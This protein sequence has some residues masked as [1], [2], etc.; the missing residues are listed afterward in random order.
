MFI[1]FFIFLNY[2][3]SFHVIMIYLFKDRKGLNFSG[4]RRLLEYFL[5][6]EEFVEENNY[7]KVRYSFNSLTTAQ[8]YKVWDTFDEP[9]N[10]YMTSSN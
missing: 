10:F 4:E 5:M 7:L 6:K 3:L 2:T 9:R 8:Q 1:K